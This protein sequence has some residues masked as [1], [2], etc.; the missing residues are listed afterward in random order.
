[1]TYGLTSSSSRLFKVAAMKQSS[2]RV[3]PAMP[4][5]PLGSQPFDLAFHPSAPL[6][7]TA[8][9]DGTLTTIN[10]PTQS[11]LKLSKRPIRCISAADGHVY[12]AGKAKA[13]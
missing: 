13:I 1:M 8:N 3:T 9:L 12:A 7:Y 4:I 6:V 11:T 10:Y 5:I 2:S